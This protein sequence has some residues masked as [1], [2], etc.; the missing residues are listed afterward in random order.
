M[1]R[2]CEEDVTETCSFDGCD[3]A[4]KT[5]KW[6]LCNGHEKQMRQGKEL[7]PLRVLRRGTCFEDSS[8]PEDLAYDA[9]LFDGEGSVFLSPNAG[10]WTLYVTLGS[11]YEAVLHRLSERWGGSVQY[12]G[13]GKNSVKPS[14]SWNTSGTNSRFFLNTVLPYLIIKKD[15]AIIALQWDGDQTQGVAVQKAIR[16]ARI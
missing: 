6:G 16:D 10:T 12:H 9:G 4:P 2:T 8:T 3:I 14:W 5:K 7:V 15:E 1:T 11:T 13:I